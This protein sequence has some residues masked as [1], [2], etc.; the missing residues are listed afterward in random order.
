MEPCEVFQ[1]LLAVDFG[2]V[3]HQ[4]ESPSGQ[5]AF[6][7]FSRVDVNLGHLPAIISVKMG[8]GMVLGVHPDDD[9]IEA[10]NLRHRPPRISGHIAFFSALEPS[11]LRA[12]RLYGESQT[13]NQ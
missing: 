7:N 11:C 6:Q 5:A 4:P 2:P 12:C 1:E 8:R 3:L 13:L 10:G 9:P